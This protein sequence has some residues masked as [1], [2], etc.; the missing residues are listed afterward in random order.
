MWTKIVGL[1]VEPVEVVETNGRICK[2]VLSDGGFTYLD[3]RRVH[4]TREAAE[5]SSD[6]SGLAI[7]RERRD[8]AMAGRG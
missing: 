2:V 3:R 6:K 1:G 8:A 7:A 4:E 5:Q